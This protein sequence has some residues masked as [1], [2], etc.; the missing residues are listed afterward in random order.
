VLHQKGAFLLEGKVEQDHRRGFSFL[1]ER[2][3]DLQEVLA[4]TVGT[5]EP[6]ICEAS[7]TKGWSPGAVNM[8]AW[9]PPSV[10]P[11]YGEGGGEGCLR[12]GKG[13]TRSAR[14]DG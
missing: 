13:S 10:M 4:D 9:T 7:T 14:G 1:V 2:I 11:G 3:Y 12:A 8:R 6:R 5:W